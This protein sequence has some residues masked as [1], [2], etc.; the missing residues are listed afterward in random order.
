MTNHRFRIGQ[1]VQLTQGYPLRKETAGAYTIVRQLP[2]V[3]GEFQ[4][5]IKSS[6]ESHERVANERDLEVA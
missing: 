3:A 4:Y 1:K 5:R 6:R 2:D